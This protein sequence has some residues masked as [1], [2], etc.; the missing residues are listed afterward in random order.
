MIRYAPPKSQI[1][2]HPVRK[3]RAVT[4]VARVLQFLDAHATIHDSPP[5]QLMLGGN[6]AENFGLSEMA[7][8]IDRTLGQAGVATELPAPLAVQL[9][10]RRWTF[11]TDMLPD[12]AA[13]FDKYADLLKMKEVFAQASTFWGFE[14]QEAPPRTP[15]KEPMGGMLGVHLGRP[16]RITTMFCFR[17]LEQ[18]QHIKSALAKLELVELSDKHLRPKIGTATDKRRTP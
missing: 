5:S 4:I 16:H 18:Y 7:A 17:D 1:W 6:A 13:W 14:W 10:H 12:V 8:E 9:G 11:S 15:P 2:G 3:L